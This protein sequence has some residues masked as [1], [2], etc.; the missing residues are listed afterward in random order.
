MILEVEEERPR[1][2]RVGLGSIEDDRVEFFLQNFD[3]TA[4]LRS[5][6]EEIRSYHGKISSLKTERESAE[7][8]IRQIHDEQ[9]RIRS[10][11]SRIS[12]DSDL[13]RR[14]VKKFQRQEDRIEELIE[15]K[16]RLT[17]RLNRL[18]DELRSY[19]SGLDV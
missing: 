11:M 1:T 2:Q 4:E 5:A 12:S 18:R 10:N 16:D 3:L 6:L 15:E 13:Y 8:E 7:A 14:Y 9:S 17:G 19:V